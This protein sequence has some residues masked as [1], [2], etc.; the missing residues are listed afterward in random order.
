MAALTQLSSF[1]ALYLMSSG[2]VVQLGPPGGAQL[3]ANPF[4]RQLLAGSKLSKHVSSLLNVT[5]KTWL[6]H[7]ALGGQ[8]PVDLGQH[9]VQLLPQRQCHPCSPRSTFAGDQME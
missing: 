6:F 3:A 2:Q 1:T 5:G 8:G 4:R 7:Q 9:S